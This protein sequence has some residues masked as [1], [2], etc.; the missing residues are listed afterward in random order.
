MFARRT[1]HPAGPNRLHQLAAER[2]ARGAPVLDL[3]VT[4]P[5]ACGLGLPWEGLRSALDQPGAAHHAPDPRGGLEARRAIAAWLGPAVD[6]DRVVLSA[7]TSEAYAWILKVLCDPGDA[8]AVPRPCYPLVDWLARLESVRT[9]PYDLHFAAGRWHVDLDS[10]ADAS[11]GAR[12]VVVIAPGNPT[13]NLLHRAEWTAV[14]RLCAERGLALVVDEVFADS[15]GVYGAL[16]PEAVTA[17]HGDRACLTFALRGLSKTCLL[18]Q[19]KLAWTAVCGPDPLVRPALERL[20]LVADTFLS[21][22]SP[23]QH[24]VPALLA[25]APA[26]QRQL[27]ERLRANRAALTDCC[28]GAALNVLPAEGG[29]SAILRIPATLPGDAAE[30]LLAECGILVHPGWFYD[31]DGPYLVVSLL[32][33]RSSFGV[34][35]STLVAALAEG[36]R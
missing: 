30:R 27:A 10:L 35:S 6:P 28:Q 12:A 8:I 13:G 32:A 18:P 9:Q 34:A 23:I 21:V 14:E 4:N 1:D 7:S 15:A 16:E 3:T 20:E 26:I 19:C 33:Q 22:G 5:T 29:W 31:L 2:H 17:I 11:Q 36:W 24:A 25:A